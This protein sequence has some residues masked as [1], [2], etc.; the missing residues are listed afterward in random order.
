MDIISNYEFYGPRGVLLKLEKFKDEITINEAGVHIPLYENFESDNGR[1]D[2]KIKVED[3]SCIGEILYIS[4]ASQKMMEDEGMEYK[5]GDR[6][7]IFRNQKTPFNQ[8]LV[9]KTNQ[10][11]KFEGYMLITPQM[12]ECKLK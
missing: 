2:S 12:I 3:Y 7:A 5:V 6:V 11:E 10:V 9:D 1:P 4:K 8:F